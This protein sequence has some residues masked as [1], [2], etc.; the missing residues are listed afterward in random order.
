[1]PSLDKAAV[2]NT[3]ECLLVT[4]I[5]AKRSLFSPDIGHFNVNHVRS[6]RLDIFAYICLSLTTSFVVRYKSLDR[7]LRKIVKNKYRYFRFYSMIK[8]ANRVRT[9]LRF[10][11]LGLALRSNQKLKDRLDEVLTDVCISPSTSILVSLKQKHQTI[12]LGA[13]TLAL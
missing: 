12:T 8:P 2:S 9:G 10:I 11:L 1:M 4:S 5:L 6:Q 3:A 7:K 13:L